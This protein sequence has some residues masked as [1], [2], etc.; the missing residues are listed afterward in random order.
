MPVHPK[1]GGEVELNI[2]ADKM[3]VEVFVEDARGEGAAAITAVF[4]GV[5]ANCTGASLFVEGG[6]AA[7]VEAQ[8]FVVG[9]SSALK[10]DD[11]IPV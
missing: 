11:V 5:C 9:A 10:S 3:I 6:A 4:G 2:L 8:A 1:P 7:E